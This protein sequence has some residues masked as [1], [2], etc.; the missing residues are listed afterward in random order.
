M[1]I[2]VQIMDYFGISGLEPGATFPEFFQFFFGCM[3]AF[4]VVIE[5]F[6]AMLGFVK[7]VSTIR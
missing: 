3:I 4:I 1:E 6:R 7:E 2:F 5:L